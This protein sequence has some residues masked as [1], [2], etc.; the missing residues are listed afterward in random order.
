VVIEASGVKRDIKLLNA[1][2]EQEVRRV[3]VTAPVNH[4]DIVNIVMGVNQQQY[5]PE[6]LAQCGLSTHISLTDK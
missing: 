5:S 2:L 3:V 6:K 1:Y 4:P